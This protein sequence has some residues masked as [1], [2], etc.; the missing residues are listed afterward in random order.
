[1]NDM[2]PNKISPTLT[3][4]HRLFGMAL[5]DVF[6]GR[7]WRVELEKEL[8]IKSQ[9]LDVL[10]IE[11]TKDAAKTVDAALID[12]LPDGLENLRAHNVMTYKSRA[13]TLDRW[14]IAEL[15]GHYV[16]YR[17]LA[18]GEAQDLPTTQDDEADLESAPSAKR[19]L[20]ESVFGLY[21][22]STRHP[23]HLMESLPAGTI[24]KT[25]WPGVYDLAWGAYPVRLIVL[26][27]IAQD[28][29]N[30]P[31]T[32]FSTHIEHIA[33]GLHHFQIRDRAAERLFP[34]LL[35][36][37]QKEIR[38]MTYTVEDFERDSKRQ[39]ID[40]F[41][42]FGFGPEELQEL[43]GKFDA[44]IRLRGMPPEERLQGIPPEIRL[45]GIPP[46]ERLRGL[47]PDELSALDAEERETLRRLLAKLDT[48]SYR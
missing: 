44:E 22:V 33:H 35:L 39:I 41:E 34:Q 15:I 5:T 25:T 24:H 7:P 12:D 10:I 28:P 18:S 17:K 2:D 45:R 40:H 26:N 38:K 13:Q 8:A 36:K 27:D 16:A 3:P 21:A 1:M 43:L 48:P 29:R 23:R 19:L 37:Y 9:R 31:W 46:E 32:L 6:V 47:D 42:L 4:W 11:Q 14:A 20:P 30:A